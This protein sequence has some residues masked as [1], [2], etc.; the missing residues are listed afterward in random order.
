GLR[1]APVIRAG[2][3]AGLITLADVLQTPHDEWARTLV[4]AA[5][6][7]LDRLVV[8]APEQE[9]NEALTLLAERDVNQVPVG[10]D[11]AVVGMLGR[12]ALVN[13][14]AT[15]GEPWNGTEDAAARVAKKL[16]PA[17]K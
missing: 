11:G 1:A 10:L 3:F 12:D 17:Q 13:S 8:G 6:T 16:R 9:G 7:P 5:M 15:Q 2:R 14:L 4:S